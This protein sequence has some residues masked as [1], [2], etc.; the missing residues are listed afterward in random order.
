MSSTAALVA[1]FVG[2]AGIWADADP[3][4]DRFD[5]A[6]CR[7][8]HRIGPLGGDSGP[9]L[10]LVGFR[11]PRGWIETWLKSPRAWKPD[12]KMPEQGL[13]ASDRGALA[14]FLSAQKGQAWGNERPWDGVSSTEKGRASS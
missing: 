12:T 14:D 2:F 1:I 8:C 4:L 5:A 13:S 3:G 9:D 11:R 6:G 10:T 7:A